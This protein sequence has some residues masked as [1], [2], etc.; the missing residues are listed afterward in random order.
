[1]GEERKKFD[2]FSYSY[3]ISFYSISHCHLKST[4]NKDISYTRKKVESIY[5]YHSIRIGKELM[6][7]HVAQ[8]LK[9][10]HT[11]LKFDRYEQLPKT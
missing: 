9:L 4:C 6:E 1:M 3:S 7:T 10:A 2:E 5:L 8:F 11:S